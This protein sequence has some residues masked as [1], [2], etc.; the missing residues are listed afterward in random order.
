MDCN[1]WK[2][3]TPILFYNPCKEDEVR[4]GLLKC[5]R[6]Q[7]TVQYWP[8]ITSLLH[9]CVV[10]STPRSTRNSGC[11]A[12][13]WWRSILPTGMRRH[14]HISDHDAKYKNKSLLFDTLAIK[15]N[16]LFHFQN[17]TL[18]INIWYKQSHKNLIT[19]KTLSLFVEND[20]PLLLSWIKRPPFFRTVQSAEFSDLWGRRGHVLPVGAFGCCWGADGCWHLVVGGLLCGGPALIG[21]LL[22]APLL[23]SQQLLSL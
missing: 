22:P 7:Q 10:E 18:N 5:C 17:L 2:V 3:N 20:S 9:I 23:L 19:Y 1:L 13:Q 8:S 11:V 15:D 21:L 14:L 6:V 4:V 16:G 12:V